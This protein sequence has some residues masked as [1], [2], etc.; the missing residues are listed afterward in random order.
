MINYYQYLPVSKEDERWGMCVLNVG[1]SRI[2]N[3]V[4]YPPIGH[5]SSHYFNWDKG[6]ILHNEY[7]VIYITRGSGVF[8]SKSIEQTN[9]EEGTIILLFPEEWHRF[10][11]NEET[12]WDEYWVGFNGSIIEN[13]ITNSF[14]TPQNAVLKIGIKDEIVTQLTE[15]IEITRGEKA[16]YQPLISSAVVHLLGRIHYLI[17]QK[18][19]KEED[20]VGMIVDKAR[21]LLRA[22]IDAHISVEEVAKELQVSYSWFRKAFK[23]YTGIAP[24]QYIIQL[25]IEKAKALLSLPD[26]PI[27]TISDKLMFESVFYFCRLFKEK[28]GITPAQYRKKILNN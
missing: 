1:C 5:P 19:S 13:L 26:K 21:V 28:T 4:K 3:E 23:A 6:R 11:P 17:K 15:I 12:G 20:F 14:F 2:E 18:D 27:K 7:Q 24:G 10:K 16:G 25:K 8:E 22:N 9:I